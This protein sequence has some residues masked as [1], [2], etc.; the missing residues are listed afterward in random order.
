MRKLLT[1]FCV[2]LLLLSCTATTFAAESEDT[3]VDVKAMYVDSTP[4]SAV[5]PDEDGTAAV[6]LPGG[7]SLT[8]SGI[9]NVGWLLVIEPVTEKEPL[10]WLNSLLGGKLNDRTALHIFFLDENGTAHSADGVTVTVQAP[11]ARAS[12][13]AVASNG[14]VTDQTGKAGAGSLSFTTNGSPFYVYGSRPHS[15]AY[16]PDTPQT[17]DN[18]HLALWFTLLT[19]SGATLLVVMVI[20]VKKDRRTNRE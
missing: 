19:L 18:T 12:A 4:W 8:V 9:Q 20:G 1:T 16:T 7:T 3:S 15:G 5:S 14:T 11:P 2:C 13:Y 6:T 17:G 10:D